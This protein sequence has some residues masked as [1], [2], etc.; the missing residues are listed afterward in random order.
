MTARQAIGYEQALRQLRGELTEHD[1][2]EQT[3]IAT[4]R[5]SRRQV[6]WFKRYAADEPALAEA[7][8]WA[9]AIAAG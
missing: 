1:A 3:R 7:G 4:R 9:S 5:L 2:Q 6:S 8:E